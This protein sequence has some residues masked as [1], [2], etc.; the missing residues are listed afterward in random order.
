VTLRHLLFQKPLHED[1]RISALGRKRTL[2][3]RVVVAG[4]WH[5]DDAGFDIDVFE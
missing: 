2:W 3:I 1:L 4:E 5:G